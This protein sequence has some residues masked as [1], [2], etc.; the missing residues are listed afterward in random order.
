MSVPTFTKV[1]PE[2]R[3]N[4]A[5][6]GIMKGLGH[7]G[8]VIRSLKKDTAII[9]HFKLCSCVTIIECISAVG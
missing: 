2:N 6:L 1:K 7:N 9:E 3:Y 5:K 8:L 4:M